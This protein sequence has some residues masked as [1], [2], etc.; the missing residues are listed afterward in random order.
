MEKLSNGTYLIRH[1]MLNVN[2]TLV[3][4]NGTFKILNSRTKEFIK[5][6]TLETVYEFCDV[7]EKIKTDQKNWNIVYYIGGEVREKI[8]MNASYGI[9]Q[10]KINALKRVSHKTGK[11]IA[12]PA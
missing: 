5:Y 4:Y 6:T 8:T 2:Y 1:K 3:A 11:L 12:V 7:I 10:S 9:V